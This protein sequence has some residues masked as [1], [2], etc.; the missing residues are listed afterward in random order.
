M[1]NILIIVLVVIVVAGGIYLIIDNKDVK[2][3]AESDDKVT[4]EENIIPDK[5]TGEDAD[6]KLE[7]ETDKTK[8]TIGTSVGGN[9][10]IAYHYGEGEDEL[11][12]IGGIHGGYSWNTSLVAY[13]LMDYLESNPEAIPTNIS[14]TVIPVMNPDGLNKVV[15]STGRFNKD[16][17]PLSETET[18]LGRF[19]EN[20]IDLNRNFDCDWQPT[21]T[22][23]DKT[24]SGGSEAFSE[25][26]SKA[27]RGYLDNTDPVAIVVWY[28]AAGGVYSSNCYDGVLPETKEITN[29]YADASSY[30]AYEE[31]DFYEITGDMV[32]WFAK[33]RIPAISIL[34]T[35]HEDIEW[36]KNKK[37]IEALLKYYAE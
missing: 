26:E 16:D 10:I 8:T 13:E 5:V 36:N 20:G 25:P 2:Y 19:N 22:W 11:L 34:L 23:K 3:T 30:P 28:S 29:V 7:E 33:E 4:V 27:I 21:G 17:V 14:I 9:D 31:F 32:N 6:K 18:I 35:N 24:V 37:G 1:K 12:F 15:G